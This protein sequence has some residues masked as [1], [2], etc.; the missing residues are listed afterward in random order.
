MTTYIGS[1]TRP[2]S[3]TRPR[4]RSIR[5]AGLVLGGMGVGIG[6]LALLASLNAASLAG[7][8][9]A[10][11]QVATSVILAFGLATAG[12]AAAKT[13]IALILVGIVRRLWVRVEAMRTTLPALIGQRAAK[14]DDLG[15]YE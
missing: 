14:P 8:E 2:A 15:D 11:D 3:G 4:A 5:K 9:G 1:V 12:L 6:T 13:G 7:S 10:S